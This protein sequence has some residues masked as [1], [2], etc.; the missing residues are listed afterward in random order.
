MTFRKQLINQ[1]VSIIPH[2]FFI[3]KY[4]ILKHLILKHLKI[5]QYFITFQFNAL[6][7]KKQAT[8]FGKIRGAGFDKQLRP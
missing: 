3:L 5:L 7:R 8:S 4:F 2:R 6:I 1:R